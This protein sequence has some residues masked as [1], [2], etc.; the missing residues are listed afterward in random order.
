MEDQWNHF[1][2][3]A[4]MHMIHPLAL[5]DQWIL[6]RCPYLMR[7]TPPLKRTLTRN[8]Q[9]IICR[10]QDIQSQTQ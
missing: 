10:S 6:F 7:T 2:C 4:M 3:Q 1:K 8:A 5:G 9:E